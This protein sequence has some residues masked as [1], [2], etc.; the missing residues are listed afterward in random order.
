MPEVSLLAACGV[1]FGSVFIL[2]ATLAAMMRLIIAIFP[3]QTP[4]IEAPMVAAISGVVA[5]RI[6]GATVIRI[7]EDV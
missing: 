6:P 1:A 4:S 3:V 7:E 2:L 5:A